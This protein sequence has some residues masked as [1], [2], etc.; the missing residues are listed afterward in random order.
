MPRNV[1][2]KDGVIGLANKALIFG[3]GIAL[4]VQIFALDKGYY[5]TGQITG[6]SRLQ[7]EAP[8]SVRPY[9]SEG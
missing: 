8:R 7:V 3:C 4:L 9:A 6:A 5:L 2:I 1:L